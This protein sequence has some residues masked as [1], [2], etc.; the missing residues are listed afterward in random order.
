[1][2][3]SSTAG[4]PC[5]G[6][7]TWPS[8]SS[9]CARSGFDTGRVDGIFGDATA[10]ALGEF[11]RNAGLPVDGIV[12]RRHPR[13]A[14]PPREPPPRPRAG[15]GGPGPG[16]PAR[17]PAHPAGPPR[18]RRRERR[19]GQRHRRA[20]PPA[21]LGRHPGDRAAPPRRLRPGQGG[22]RAR[23]STSSSGSGSIPRPQLPDRLL[24][25]APR[26]VAPAGAGWPSW[27]RPRVPEALGRH[28]R[29]RPRHVGAPPARDPDAC[30]ALRGRARPAGWSRERPRW[31]PPWP[32]RSAAG[33]TPPGTDY[34]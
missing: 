16:R 1:M 5:C 12:G 19:P 26:R 7:T 6:A 20:A 13:G 10:R 23:R 28:R 25:R 17:R 34:R 3:A 30:S 31:P 14:R 21:D 32:R 2:T 4:P 8:C 24:V 9:A 11:Q 27:S 29:R 33:P 22:Q 18:G 15:L